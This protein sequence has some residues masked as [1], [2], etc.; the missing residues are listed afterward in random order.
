MKTGTLSMLVGSLL[1][2]ALSWSQSSLGV[3]LLCD[4]AEIGAP[5]SRT[6]YRLFV[7][8]LRQRGVVVAQTSTYAYCSPEADQMKEVARTIGAEKIYLLTISVLGEKWILSAEDRGSSL[9]PGK[10][11]V[12]SAA[13]LE[14]IDRLMPRLVSALIEDVKV[15]TTASLESVSQEE[16]R[17]W[18]KKPGERLWGIGLMFGG[19]LSQG[20][21]LG[22]GFELSLAYEME[23]WRLQA[24]LAGLSASSTQGD[25]RGRGGTE[26][27]RIGLGV[28]YLFSIGEWSPLVGARLHYLSLDGPAAGSGMGLTILGGVELFRLHRARMSLTL[29]CTLPFFE[30]QESADFTDSYPSSPTP[31]SAYT[32]VFYSAVALLW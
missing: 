15:E 29:G 17:R 7:D 25:E 19:D 14:E 22:H 18:E 23:R 27:F 11:Q 26:L 32:P 21:A 24:D 30:T 3:A 2:P 6:V 20:N 4:E 10:K 1:W 31:R 12:I 5:S 28:D 8:A 13:E 9:E 16:G